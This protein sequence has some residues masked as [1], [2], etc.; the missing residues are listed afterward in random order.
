MFG[1]SVHELAAH[2]DAHPAGPAGYVRST[3]D[4][5]AVDLSALSPQLVDVE[6]RVDRVRQAA[7]RAKWVLS[8]PLRDAPVPN[9][10][11]DLPRA[12]QLLGLLSRFNLPHAYLVPVSL[13]SDLQEQLAML[14]V[15]PKREEQVMGAARH[16]CRQAREAVDAW[17]GN[18]NQGRDGRSA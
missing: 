12:G 14:R 15:L 9:A 16:L 13:L 18:Q 3:L 4:S 7:N 8:V 2:A 11:A 5:I 10:E 6:H 1:I 17:L